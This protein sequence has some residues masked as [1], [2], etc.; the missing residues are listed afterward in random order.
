[1]ASEL[2]KHGYLVDCLNSSFRK[3]YGRYEVSLS[4][5]FN[6]ILTQYQ[7]WLSYR[8]YFPPISLP[9]YRAWPSPNYEWFPWSICNGCGM[10]AGNAYPSGHLVPCPLF[11][12]WLCSNCWDQ[13]ALTCR[14]FTR[15]LTLN[16]PRYFRFCLVITKCNI[17][18]GINILISIYTTQKEFK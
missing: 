15:L 5:M 7:Q 10:P 14:V 8:S 11:G 3:F 18:S 1:M 9:W 17:D 2:P 6:G 12:T 13:I 16:T 4:Q